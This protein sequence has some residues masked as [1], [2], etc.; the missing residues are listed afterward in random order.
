M[1]LV[2]AGVTVEIVNVE[3]R[4]GCAPSLGKDSLAWKSYMGN[5][6]K[7]L[8]SGPK[9][10]PLRQYIGLNLLLGE[11]KETQKGI[12]LECKQQLESWCRRHPMHKKGPPQWGG[13]FYLLF[14]GAGGNRTRVRQQS[15]CRST[16]LAMFIDLSLHSPTGRT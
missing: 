3:L 2:I 5:Q 13:P 14:G 10:L 12:S 11:S 1:V 16:C 15:I 4:H 9:A 8:G 7:C 6:K